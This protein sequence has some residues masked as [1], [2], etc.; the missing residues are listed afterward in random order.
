MKKLYRKEVTEGLGRA[1]MHKPVLI[2]EADIIHLP[3]PVKKYLSYV[4]VIG[5]EKIWNARIRFTGKIRSK[6]DSG[7]MKFNSEQYNFFDIPTRI[8]YIKARMMGIP[9]GG[10]HLYKNETAF[11]TIKI[12]GLF[13]IVDARGENMD[14]AETVTILNDMC[15]MAPATLIDKSIKWETVDNQTVKA[16]LTV[17][18]NSISGILKFNKEGQLI[19]FISN[20]RYETADGKTLINYPWSTPASDY[21]EINGIRLATKASTIYHHPDKDFCYGEFELEDVRYNCLEQ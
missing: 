20:D 15:F 13:T 4:G 1:G 5:K 2:T 7:W 16:K 3:E 17:G 10:L 18:K 8:F 6:P 11:M 9:A 19:N 14:Q 21:R 12:M